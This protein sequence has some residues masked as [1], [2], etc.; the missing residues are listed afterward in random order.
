VSIDAEDRWRSGTRAGPSRASRSRPTT[1]I[2][3]CCSRLGRHWKSFYDATHNQVM[4]GAVEQGE[5][6]TLAATGQRAGAGELPPALHVDR[7][8][9]AQGASDLR[10]R[11]VA[12]VARFK[13][14]QP[15]IET[16]VLASQHF[17]GISWQ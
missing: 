15:L 2:Q 17:S 10:K 3:D 13:R 1:Q 9:G 5:R 14:R 8:Q 4:N 16:Q 11:E 7:G 12:E 6:R